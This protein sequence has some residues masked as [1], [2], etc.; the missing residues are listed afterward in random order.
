M[1]IK[2][3]AIGLMFAALPVLA[4]D[5]DGDWVGSL[6]TPGGAVEVAF[7]FK[8]DGAKLTG[9]SIGPDGAVL[10][11]KQG[12]VEGNKLSFSMDI[13]FGGNVMTLNYTGV[14]ENKEIKMNL[15]FMDQPMAFVLKKKAP[16][17]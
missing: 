10:E 15:D 4:A 6:D 2:A 8:V 11:L 12:K 5:A 13:D 7:Q 3:L 14:V 1:K 17:G 9:T 16:A